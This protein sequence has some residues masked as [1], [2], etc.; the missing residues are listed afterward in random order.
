MEPSQGI[1]NRVAIQRIMIG[2]VPKTIR[3][4]YTDKQ[5]ETKDRHVEPYEI[6]G[7]QLF[8]HCLEKD[9][10]RRFE[11]DRMAEITEG[12]TFRPRHPMKTPM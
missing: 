5:G 7:T 10:I 6:Q 1:M 11:L 8:A 4:S 3:F 2:H 9:S 12:D